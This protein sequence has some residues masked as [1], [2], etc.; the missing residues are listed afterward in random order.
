M[1][2]MLIRGARNIIESGGWKVLVGVVLLVGQFI[3]ADELAQYFSEPE[4]Y[5]LYPDRNLTKM[6]GQLESHL[7][8]PE[9][10]YNYAWTAY[11]EGDYSTAENYIEK[12]IALRPQNAFL[13]YVAGKIYL[14]AGDKQK[15]REHFEKA[16][17][18]HYEYLD[19]WVELVKLAPE[20][21][22]NL[23]QLYAEKAHRLMKRELA[24]KAIEH[25]NNYL[26]KNPDGEFADAARAGIRDMNL[27][28]SEIESREKIAKSREEQQKLLA[29]RRLARIKEMKQFRS[30]HRRL[31]GF[32]LNNFSPS[33]DYVF[34][35]R[36]GKYSL[37]DTIR[38]KQIRTSLSEYY[39]N[40]GYFI[41]AF[42]VRGG[43]LIGQNSAK[44]QYVQDS[45]PVDTFFT[46]TLIQD[47]DT[48]FGD[49]IVIKK[50]ISNIIGGI[51]TVRV[52]ADVLY[53]FYYA[54][55][56]LLYAM[57]GFDFGYIY[58]SEK[59]SYFKSVTV[60]G[61]GIGGGVM[62]RLGNFLIELNYKY[63]I[64]GSSSGGVLSL[65]ALYKF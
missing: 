25:Y 51:N 54:N 60:A 28:L 48:T 49:T 61:V 14:A 6:V 4:K 40:V 64:A 15:A 45:I 41:D 63:N 3:Y 56:L 55:P 35:L 44:Y 52:N 42:I 20:Y 17:E 21:Y 29:D 36:E 24:E 26:S 34:T 57:G 43:L 23:A 27:L 19:A 10:L 31:V 16:L 46:D 47:G 38:L 62:L 32:S 18:N 22:Y 33:E 12:A 11:E 1:V 7:N 65:G 9:F 8:D 59:E 2:K 58:L 30:T 50:P 53:N 39:F 5:K 13:H 37:T